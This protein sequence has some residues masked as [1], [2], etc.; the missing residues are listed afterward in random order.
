MTEIQKIERILMLR[1]VPE[2]VRAF[3]RARLRTIKAI[4]LVVA[5]IKERQ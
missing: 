3:L 5:F 2:E 4:E 1:S